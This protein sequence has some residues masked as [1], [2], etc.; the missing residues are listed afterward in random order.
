MSTALATDES[1]PI[2]VEAAVH[3]TTADAAARRVP[4]SL[5]GID[6][7][8]LREAFGHFPQ[9]VVVVAAEVDGRPEGLVASTFTV[10][11]SLEPPLV[12]V[13]VQH[14]STTWPKLAGAG[15]ELGISLVG[16][17]QSALCRKIASKDRENRFTGLRVTTGEGGAVTLDG[18]PVTF[19]TRIHDQVRAGDHDIIVLELLDLAVEDRSQ[20]LVFHQSEFKALGPLD[21]DA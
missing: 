12:T 9:G 21:A 1:R 4:T 2:T 8:E 11:V 14:S 13:A 10:G 18:A 3:H 7:L 19:T 15:A 17:G 20:A 16:H 5:V 6:P